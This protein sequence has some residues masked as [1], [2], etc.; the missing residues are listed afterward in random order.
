MNSLNPPSA[1]FLV[2]P[3]HFCFNQETADSNSFQKNSTESDSE[4]RTIVNQE[5]ENMLA[6]LKKHK[7]NYFVFDS[8]PNEITPDAVFPNNWISL[9]EDGKVILYPM[10]AVNRRK[11]RNSAIIEELKKQFQINE[12]I[13]LSSYEDK[14]RFLE[15]T[16]SLI[17]DHDYKVIYACISPRTNEELANLVAERL[18]YS[19]F[20]FSAQDAKGKE[21]Y[22]TNVVMNVGSTYAVICLDAIENSLEREL[23]RQKL[24][25]SEK[26]I[27]EISFN[28]LLGFA[29]NMLEVKNQDNQSFLVMSQTAFDLLNDEQKQLLSTEV[30]LLPIAIPTIEKIGGGS[31][32]CMLTGIHLKKI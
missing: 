10:M 16:G 12:L 24:I 6:E 15:G 29:G 2:K 19:L 4:L 27:I 18:G 11:E 21:I 3:E 26:K 25:F 1:V 32:R 30:K 8:V 22:H 9:H 28:Q 7:I 5:F 13:D 17:F 23:I 31:V 14:N 20:L